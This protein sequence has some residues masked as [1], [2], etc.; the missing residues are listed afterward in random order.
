MAR[1][2]YLTSGT[3]NE[4]AYL[5]VQSI[6]ERSQDGQTVRV[7]QAEIYRIK[8]VGKVPSGLAWVLAANCAVPYQVAR[9]EETTYDDRGKEGN[10]TRFSPAGLPFVFEDHTVTSLFGDFWLAACKGEGMQTIEH[11]MFARTPAE[12]LATLRR[13]SPPVAGGKK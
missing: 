8:P 10:R 4:R 6:Q 2:L 1:D 13:P 5:D 3:Q 11:R 7:F 9:V 12:V